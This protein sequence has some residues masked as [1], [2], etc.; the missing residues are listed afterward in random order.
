MGLI[1]NSFSTAA[2]SSS[3]GGLR[4]STLT[5]SG[6]AA[7]AAPAWARARELRLHRLRLPA[8][9]CVAGL[10]KGLRKGFIAAGASVCVYNPRAP[11]MDMA[12]CTPAVLSAMTAG[13]TVTDLHWSDRQVAGATRCERQTLSCA[14]SF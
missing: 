3:L 8:E 4:S 10:L 6:G 5:E 12:Q 2:T 11:S 7:S 14:M 1:E 9:R 13:N